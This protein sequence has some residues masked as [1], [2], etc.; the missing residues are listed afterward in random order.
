MPLNEFIT[1]WVTH[2]IEMC[3]RRGY[4]NAKCSILYTLVQAG[5]AGVCY[6]Y[7][8]GSKRVTFN[9]RQQSLIASHPK[10]CPK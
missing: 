2:A 7:H 6:Y 3:A 8:A 9:L 1:N 10:Y 5:S 4:R